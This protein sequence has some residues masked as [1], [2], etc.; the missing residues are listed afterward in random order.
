[1]SAQLNC[2]CSFVRVFSHK[3]AQKVQNDFCYLRTFPR[4]FC[5]LLLAC[6]PKRGAMRNTVRAAL[7][8]LVI[9]L[10]FNTAAFA[11]SRST[12][13]TGRRRR[14]SHKMHKTTTRAIYTSHF[15]LL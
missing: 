6:T 10:S 5:A 12:V 15:H 9:N 8:L 14:L 4:L 11:Q 13:S 3:K 7:A 2:E 1:M